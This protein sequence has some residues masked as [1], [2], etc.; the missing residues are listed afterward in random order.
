MNEANRKRIHKRSKFYAV[1]CFFLEKNSSS[2]VLAVLLDGR[3]AE[4]LRSA[5]IAFAAAPLYFATNS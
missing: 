4:C 1:F 3:L 5:L 2:D